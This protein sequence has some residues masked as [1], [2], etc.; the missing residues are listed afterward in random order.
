M[1]P[2]PHDVPLGLWREWT[3][4]GGTT[5]WTALGYFMSIPPTKRFNALTKQVCWCFG[6]PLDAILL[7]VLKDEHPRP[8][9]LVQVRD[10]SS[11]LTSSHDV[12]VEGR[13]MK[14]VRACGEACK[15]QLHFSFSSDSSRVGHLGL[16]SGVMV[17]PSNTAF[18]M[19]PQASYTFG[20]FVA[21]SGCL[22]GWL[23]VFSVWLDVFSAVQY[24]GIREG[25]LPYEKAFLTGGGYFP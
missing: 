2:R 11:S 12:V 10:S 5:H 25:R 21:K 14:H 23:A 16:M 19:A 18:C 15:G 4:P 22:S 17:L 8:D 7:E 13:L 3:A 9:G 24:R 6:N 20:V 1:S